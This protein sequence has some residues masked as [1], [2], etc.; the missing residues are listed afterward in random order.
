MNVLPDVPL[1]IVVLHLAA[2][3]ALVSYGVVTQV[4]RL[5]ILKH[6]AKPESR[7]KKPFRGPAQLSRVRH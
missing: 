7:V 5:Q 4:R 3:V 2:L 1:L 6:E